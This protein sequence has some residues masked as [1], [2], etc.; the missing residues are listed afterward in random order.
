MREAIERYEEK[1]GITDVEE[2]MGHK[3]IEETY[4][5]YR[6]LMPGSITEAARTLDV[7]LRA[8]A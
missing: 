6:H 7:G 4:R 3:S 1:H 2:W 8:A 5:T